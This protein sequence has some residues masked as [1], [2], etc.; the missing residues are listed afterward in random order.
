VLLY[1][2]DLECGIVIACAGMPLVLEL[3]GSRLR[4]SRDTEL[5]KVLNSTIAFECTLSVSACEW[6]YNGT[7]Y[8]SAL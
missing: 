3:A 7:L 8:A 1:L 6:L 2:Q 5:W 4:Y